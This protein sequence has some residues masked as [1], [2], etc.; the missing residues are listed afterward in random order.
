MMEAALERV[1]GD[2]GKSRLWMHRCDVR[3]FSAIGSISARALKFGP[4]NPGWRPLWPVEIRGP[5]SHNSGAYMQ[6][7]E[8]TPFINRELKRFGQNI[9]TCI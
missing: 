2:G 4:L 8:A 6:K 3:L 9:G 7:Q 5:S 1:D